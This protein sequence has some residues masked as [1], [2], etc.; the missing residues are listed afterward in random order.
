MYEVTASHLPS[1]F[2]IIKSPFILLRIVVADIQN[3]E[4]MISTLRQAFY[5]PQPQSATRLLFDSAI[6]ITYNRFYHELDMIKDMR[7]PLLKTA[8]S[9]NVPPIEMFE[10][11]VTKMG[12]IEVDTRLIKVAQRM[13][14]EDLVSHGSGGE[15]SNALK[16]VFKA[17]VG[18]ID[19]EKGSN[20]QF[21]N[22]AWSGFCYLAMLL[23]RSDFFSR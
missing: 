9:V 13:A 4:K 15:G 21:L 16:A 2:R 6:S 20:P 10:K 22:V 19:S 1:L 11:L 23:V 17:F 18:M 5:D 3:G 8:S 14:K 7:F 12:D